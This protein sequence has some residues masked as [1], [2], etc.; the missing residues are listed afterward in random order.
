MNL[1]NIIPI[2][3]LLV[4]GTALANAETGKITFDNTIAEITLNDFTGNANT[5]IATFDVDVLKSYLIAGAP[6]VTHQLLLL[7]PTNTTDVSKI[8]VTTN[9]SSNGT[10]YVYTSGLY[11]IT[12]TANNYEIGMSAC[13]LYGIIPLARY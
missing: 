12:H 8:G 7:K 10:N 1:K 5:I 13:G 3:T 9:F 11:G 2:T 4:A 6:K